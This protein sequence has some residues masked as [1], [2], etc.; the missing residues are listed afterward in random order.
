MPKAD[1]AGARITL[2]T[3][4]FVMGALEARR[5]I[6][7]INADFREA[8]SGM[9]DWRK[10]IDGVTYKLVELNELVD[11][12]TK[13]MNEYIRRQQSMGARTEE[14]K[15]SYDKLTASIQ[16]QRTEINRLNRDIGVYT[17]ILNQLTNE[18]NRASLKLDE[19]NKHIQ[20]QGFN[21]TSLQ[22]DFEA[23]QYGMR[24]WENSLDG[25]SAKMD[26]LNEIIQIQNRI[27]D[28]YQ[29]KIERVSRNPFGTDE[30]VQKLR[31]EYDDARVTLNKYRKELTD[32]EQKLESFNLEQQKLEDEASEARRPVNLLT[33]E[34]KEQ[35]DELAK[36]ILDYKDIVATSGSWSHEAKELEKRIKFLNDELQENRNLLNQ[37]NGA[38]PFAEVVSPVGTLPEDTGRGFT[39]GR[40]IL[41]NIASDLLLSGFHR[42]GD[43]FR[44]VIDIGIEFESAFTGVRRTVEGTEED[45]RV[46]ERELLAMSSQVTASISEIADMA[47]LAGQ[48]GI[49]TEQISEFTRIMIMLGDTTNITAEEAGDSLARLSNL[50][51]LTNDDFERMGSAIVDLGNKF[52]TTESDIAEMASRLAGTANMLGITADEVFGIANAIST[53]GLEAEMGGNAISKTLR[54][55]QLAVENGTERLDVFAE[56]GGLTVDEFVTLFSNEAMGGATEALRL[57]VNGLG[58][59]DRLGRS[60]TQ[61]LNELNITELRQVDTL[62]RLATNSDTLN[63]SLEVARNAWNENLALSIEA[64][65]RYDTTESQIAFMR[66]AWSQL[67][68]TIEKEFNPA[69]RWGVDLLTDFA[70]F[71]NGN[72]LASENLERDLDTL[73]SK[74]SELSDAQAILKGSI[75]DTN[76]V[77]YLQS[78]MASSGAMQDLAGTVNRVFG[79]ASNAFTTSFSGDFYTDPTGQ[80]GLSTEDYLNRA[81]EDLVATAEE[82]GFSSAEDMIEAYE[83]GFDGYD[84][85]K[86]QRE[87]IGNT[88]NS[89]TETLVDFQSGTKAI[90]DD[91]NALLATADG[92]A[93]VIRSGDMTMAQALAMT[94]NVNEDFRGTFEE[95]IRSM[96]N[97]DIAED[98]WLNHIIENSGGN[99]DVLEST[100]NQLDSYLTEQFVR[101][102]SLGS[103][104]PLDIDENVIARLFMNRE[105]LAS[106]I[107][108]ETQAIEDAGGSDTVNEYGK[109]VALVADAIADFNKSLA[110]QTTLS[111]ALG[112]SEEDDTQARMGIYQRFIN[113]LIED[114]S[115]YDTAMESLVDTDERYIK[116]AEQK[117]LAEEELARVSEE[118]RSTFSEYLTESSSLAEIQKEWNDGLRQ[119]AISEEQLGDKFDYAGGKASLADRI[120]NKLI[121]IDPSEMTPEWEEFLSTIAELTSEGSKEISDYQKAVERFDDINVLI[122]NIG[123]TFAEGTQAYSDQMTSAGS[124]AQSLITV[125][126]GLD[127]KNLTEDEIANVESMIDELQAIVD[128]A[129]TQK[130]PAP[131]FNW[132]DKFLGRDEISDKQKEITDGLE[133]M[134]SDIQSV[135]DNIGQSIFDMIDQS[136]QNQIDQISNEINHLDNL[137]EEE[138]AKIE[139]NRSI[140][141][142]MLRKQLKEGAIDEETYYRESAKNKYEA[143]AQ[144]QKAEEE[145]Q[146]KK[147]NLMQ[148]QDALERKQFESNKANQIAQ[149]IMDT[150]SAIIKSSTSL[151]WPWNLIPMNAMAGIGAAQLAVASAQQYTPALATGGIVTAPTTALIGEAGK[152][153]VLPLEQNTDW[154][155]ELAYRIGS[156]V[157]SDR[158]RTAIDRTLNEDGRTVDE[159]K[160]MQF[161]QIINSPKALSRK[162]IYRDTRRLF[163]MVDRR[164]S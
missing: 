83:Q 155:D 76:Y 156:I 54:E 121:A 109:S 66:N 94:S 89:Y 67:S 98:G 105:A 106:Y 153:A 71:L 79:N 122:E 87:R 37:V 36:L 127:R 45:F 39:I 32:V 47:S 82:F 35:E 157:T 129:G 16:K 29:K 27:V 133:D 143:E 58:D 112:L 95:L 62:S 44:K 17:G 161:T 158:I 55:M 154:M 65:K 93:N 114:I 139:Q 84:F 97:Y 7:Q 40:G 57:F 81:R 150:A 160:N 53:V 18:E 140:N 51:N 146:T 34:I 41:S 24:L 115:D 125:L 131:Q 21:I 63:D 12:N 118:Y 11:V 124:K 132:W 145:T 2:D 119:L 110:N 78:L 8:T 91:M 46:L 86:R 99:L 90:N 13:A 126:L 19:F 85:S 26:N 3:Q 48:M 38:D 103:D 80:I 151:P 149:I 134:M 163:R 56:V 100:L 52:P 142:N 137:L 20:K 74:I 50:L 88:I 138:Q 141:E 113:N 117:K 49:P 77:M 111:E 72:S 107:A 75:E 162:E 9:V 68:I 116:S 14:N 43:A 108:K 104:N 144:K 147:K 102:S 69:I 101:L 130:D 64:G 148:Q 1:V 22:K 31:K 73:V 42:I 28:D 30:D 25:F 33:A 23:G 15:N 136:I 4:E 60:T 159:T 10:N 128:S 123:K 5:A 70:E 92:I 152:E 96:S 164:T 6:T 61:I 120:F 59:V 135:F